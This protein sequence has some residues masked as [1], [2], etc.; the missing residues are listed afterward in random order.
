MNTRTLLTAGIVAGPIFLA[1]VAAQL[2]TRDGFD[3]SRHPI[4]LLS[5]GA[6]GWVQITNFVVAGVLCC[7]FAVGLGRVL[8][9]GRGHVWGPRLMGLYGAG[10]VAGGVFVADPA[11]GYPV[12]TPDAIPE[13]L[14]WH[15]TVHAVVPPVAFG[16]LVAAT[17]V[18][19][20]RFHATGRLAWAGYSAA[21]GA[22]SLVVLGWPHAASLSW[23]LAIAVTIGFAWVSAVAVRERAAPAAR[24]PSAPTPQR[25]EA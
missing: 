12:G 2:L 22:V 19:A 8:T 9:T 5:L 20:L 4:S 14:S 18:L 11:L 3:I 1:I 10:L 15:A 6:A 23:R 7:G 16:A 24:R 21:S 13:S 25:T 17:V